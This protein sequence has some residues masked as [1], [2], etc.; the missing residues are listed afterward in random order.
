[1]PKTKTKITPPIGRYI[2]PLTDFGFKKIFGSELNKDVLIAFLNELFKGRKVIRDLVYNS[3][4]KNR[5]VKDYR[6]SFFDL[7]CT[8]AD[9]ETFIIEVQRADQ[10]FFTD[11]AVYYTAG[12]LHEQGPKGK[13]DWNFELK[14][15]YFIAIMDFNFDKTQPGKYL[16]YVRL[17]EEETGKTFYDK[18]SFIFIDLPNFNIE[19]KDIKTNI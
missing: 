14:E 3:Q 9:G 1:M 6:S 17:A 11:R 8:G 13:K 15:V 4:E 18:L 16:H 19:E 5:P 12:K 10:K 2:D 7:T